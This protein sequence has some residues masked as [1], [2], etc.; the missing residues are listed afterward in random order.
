MAGYLDAYG[1]TDARRAK[2]F[3][4]LIL[5]GIGLVIL[6]AV[7]YFQFRDFQ[8]E[9]RISAF[10]DALRRQDYPS[11]YQQWGCS[12]TTPCRDYNFEKFMGDWGPGSPHAKASEAS[13]VNTLGCEEGVLA[14][15]RFPSEPPVLLWVAR[16]TG[17]IGFFPW[18]FRP[19]PDDAKSRT[20]L[21]MW[22]LT[23]NCKPLIE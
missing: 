17:V 2:T 8:E 5:G 7:L 4:W 21:W 9:R 12:E 13:V 20:A 10:L 14:D 6:A 16:R 19:V 3:K 22:K 18:K 1:T 15:L 11:A 23:R